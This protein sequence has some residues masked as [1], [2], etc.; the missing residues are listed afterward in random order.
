VGLRSS[1]LY[2]FLA[3]LRCSIAALF[4][5]FSYCCAIELPS[6]SYMVGNYFF[7]FIVAYALVQ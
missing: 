4:F 6:P 3:A 1:A 2:F 5:L 7:C